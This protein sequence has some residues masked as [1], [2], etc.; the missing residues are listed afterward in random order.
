MND[1]E[2]FEQWK[3]R[4]FKNL[5]NA[6]TVKSGKVNDNGTFFSDVSVEYTNPHRGDEKADEK[7]QEQHKGDAARVPMEMGKKEDFDAKMQELNALCQLW[8]LMITVHFY[9]QMITIN[10]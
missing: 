8:Q 2:T 4:A 3:A 10:K 1:W 5:Q 9:F 6:K 7:Q